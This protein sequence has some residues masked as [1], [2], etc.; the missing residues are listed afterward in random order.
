M[1][2]VSVELVNGELVVVSGECA[3]ECCAGKS[4][5][6]SQQVLELVM[7]TVTNDRPLISQRCV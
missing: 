6:S 5:F 4:C 2:L 3:I 1:E 7:A